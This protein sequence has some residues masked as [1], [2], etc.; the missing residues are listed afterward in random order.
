M[1][2]ANINHEIL[3]WARNRAGLTVDDAAKKLNV[4]NSKI[5]EWETGVKR[6]TFKQAVNL[7]KLFSM[8]FGYLFISKPPHEELP[9]PD[10]RTLGSQKNQVISPDLSAIIEKMQRRQSWFREYL[11]ELN[12]D[13]NKAVGRFN[14]DSG[15]DE[16]VADLREKL[17]VG[18]CP[19]KGNWEDY[20]KDLVS[21]IEDVGILVMRQ[22]F[23]QFNSRELDIE[24]F[25]GFALMDD[26]APLLF[27]NHADV[28]Y[29]RIFTLIHELAHLWIGS[30]GISDVNIHNHHQEE[31]LCNA[32]AGEFLVPRSV[33]REHWNNT[34][35]PW[36]NQLDDLKKLFHVSRWVL[37]RRA[38]SLKF[39]SQEE[40]ES[41]INNLRQNFFSNQKKAKGGGS[42]YSSRAYE[43]SKP[44]S[45][46]IIREINGGSL[47]MRD[48]ANLLSLKPKHLKQFSRK[49]RAFQ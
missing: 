6:P 2:A 42:F 8:P 30:S 26:Y 13:K 31:K 5:K 17:Q 25:R 35:T 49:I 22:R 16:I 45:Q 28:P 3:I 44:F 27:I 11:I 20:Y 10:L 41:Y 37:A 36:Y 4:K 32:V 19:D 40:Y 43:V 29:A 14:I 33:L 9:I 23:L 34:I 47:L 48:G 1:N 24:E 12:A 15:A 46:A 7:A 39:I 18:I 38:L 21:R